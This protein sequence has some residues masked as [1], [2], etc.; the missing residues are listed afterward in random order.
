MLVLPATVTLEVARDNVLVNCLAPG[1]IDT[2]LTRRILGPRGLREAARQV[3]QGRLAR[4][5]EIARYARFLASD[6]NSYMTGQNIVVDGG[7][8]SA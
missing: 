7:Y 6:E 4:P 5:E 2:D 3:P 8:V 1:F